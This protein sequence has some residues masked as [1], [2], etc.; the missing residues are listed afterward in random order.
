MIVSG[1]APCTRN[2]PSATASA[3]ADGADGADGAV[4]CAAAACN[5]NAVADTDAKKKHSVGHTDLR[6]PKSILDDTPYPPEHQC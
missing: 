6:T 4:V 5:V 2:V 1:V 3:G